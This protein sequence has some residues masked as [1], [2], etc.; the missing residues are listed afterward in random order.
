MANSASK[1]KFHILIYHVRKKLFVLLIGVSRSWEH[2]ADR[3]SW[4]TKHFEDTQIDVPKWG[5]RWRNRQAAEDYPRSC[6]NRSKLS[7]QG[8]LQLHKQVC[9]DT[10]QKKNPLIF[11]SILLV[12]LCHHFQICR[13][14]A[15]CLTQYSRGKKLQLTDLIEEKKL[16]KLFV[17]IRFSG[18]WLFATPST[19][20]HQTTLS[21]GFSRQEYW[22]GLPCPPPG[23]FPDP[24]IESAS[25]VSPAL[26]DG[27]FTTSATRKAQENCLKEF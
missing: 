5:I 20:A 24:G 1:V 18:V 10:P 3:Q 9:L 26:A 6:K 2:Q 14:T 23:D 16:K 4:N 7:T 13:D 8:D 27:F 12:I 19:V 21:M 22:S 15:L 17:L 11:I 25:L